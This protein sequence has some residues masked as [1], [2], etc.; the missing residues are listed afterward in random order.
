MRLEAL[1]GCLV[2]EGFDQ[3]GSPSA[4]RRVKKEPLY[5][6]REYFPHKSITIIGSHDFASVQAER[7]TPPNA[8]L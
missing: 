4:P 5:Y 3:L 2:I 1:G 8:N 7:Q 6:P